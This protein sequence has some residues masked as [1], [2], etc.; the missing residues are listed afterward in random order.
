MNRPLRIPRK[1][2]DKASLAQWLERLET[3]H[4]NAIDLG[5]E[6]VACVANT[7]GLLPLAQPVITVA[8]TNGKGS[9]VA[10]LEAIIAQVGLVS[11]SFSSP[12]L[13]RFNERIRI[14]G[15][16]AADTEIVAAFA[17]VE[18]ARGETGLTY[19]EFAALAA[20]LVF[21]ARNPDIVVLE[22]GL[23]GRLDAVNIVDPAVAVITSIDLDHQE[24]LGDSRGAI[25]LEK[26]GIV[27]SGKP[28]VIG[29][30]QPPAELLA[31]AA[32]VG[33]HPVYCLGQD[34]TVEAAATG[35][36]GVLRDPGGA[37]RMLPE[38][39]PGPLLPANICSALQAAVAVGLEFSDAQLDLALATARPRGR[40]E[41]L[42]LV[43]KHYVLDVA[44]NPA[45]VNNLVDYLS[46]TDC[47]G[48]TIALFS[49]MADKDIRGML[50]AASAS[51]T[52]WF[53]ADQPANQR[54]ARA[55]DVA[56]LL[57]AGGQTMVSVSKNLRQALRRAQ[58]VMTEG[59]RLV[60]F[61]SFY[62]VGEAA[63]L[64]DK[65]RPVGEA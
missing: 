50:K 47:K 63:L 5:L 24:W 30:P 7:L 48:K 13:L 1:G 54:A 19:F 21:R 22:V 34:F 38:Q 57:H 28:L 52:G 9:T 64:L 55:A 17:A 4:P 12:H 31:A 37:A 6:R 40:C 60:V 11:G 41:E 15:A 27:R 14:G 25:A 58:Q 35:W 43:G 20:L 65:D 29:D 26:A 62:T 42:L 46:A 10:V 39:P 59:D 61:G 53:L 45:A 33:A 56:A 18:Q 16:V 51:F 3:L 44:H 49:A 36:R 32:E 23:G 2:M 8:G